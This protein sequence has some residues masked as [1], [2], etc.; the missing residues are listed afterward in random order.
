MAPSHYVIRNWYVWCL[1][2]T[3]FENTHFTGPWVSSC[4]LPRPDGG[5]QDELREVDQSRALL[6]FV[7][8]L[9]LSLQTL[10]LCLEQPW[11]GFSFPSLGFLE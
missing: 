2:K 1:A 3:P 4:S 6:L 11:L 8:A 5:A 9:L 7:P 10:S